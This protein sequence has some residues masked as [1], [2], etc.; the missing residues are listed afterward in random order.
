M[1][2]PGAA[3]DR[4]T[5]VDHQ[6]RFSFL[7]VFLGVQLTAVQAGGVFL[8]EPTVPVLQRLRVVA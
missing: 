3:R 5:T 7:T 2:E 1:Y 8:L 4:R 6:S